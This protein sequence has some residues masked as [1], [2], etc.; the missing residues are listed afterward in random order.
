MPTSCNDVLDESALET[1]ADW[2]VCLGRHFR[3]NIIMRGMCMHYSTLEVGK[4]LADADF[5]N[6]ACGEIRWEGDHLCVVLT[7]NDSKAIDK[8]IV[9]ELP[10]K[11]RK[12]GCMC[13][14]DDGRKELVHCSLPI[15]CS[16]RFRSL[17]NDDATIK[18]RDCVG[19]P[20]GGAQSCSACHREYGLRVGS[21]V[22]QK[23]TKGGK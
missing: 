20:Q 18:K 12:I 11:L 21:C 22:Q 9:S 16:N 7:L 3:A 13:V 10:A 2:S 8:S 1:A 19:V 17:K 5:E 14:L 15:A 23:Q 4:I 6:L